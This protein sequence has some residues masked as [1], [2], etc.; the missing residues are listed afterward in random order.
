VGVGLAG[1]C[2]NAHTEP[3]RDAHNRHIAREELH[4]EPGYATVARMRYGASEQRATNAAAT[5]RWEDGEPNFG[6]IVVAGKMCR[7]NE[8]KPIIVKAE[9]CVVGEVHSVD[10]GS[11]C[12]WC[13][14]RAEAQ[15]AVPHRQGKKVRHER[16]ACGFIQALDG[17]SCHRAR[18]AIASRAIGTP[19]PWNK[20]VTPVRI[21]KAIKVDK[22]AAAMATVTPWERSGVGFRFIAFLL[23]FDSMHRS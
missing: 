20:R 4:D 18:S 7:T 17:E 6:E 22:A 10:V 9:D 16:G 1:G 15:A 8:H 5:V 14:R 3:P 11:D 21:P 12:L 13:K 19:R 2:D 23:R